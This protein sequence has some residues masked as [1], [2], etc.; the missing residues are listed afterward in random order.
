MTA[1]HVAEVQIRDVAEIDLRGQSGH[2]AHAQ[3]V[4]IQLIGLMTTDP[5]HVGRIFTPT[6][7]NHA[8]CLIPAFRV[9][10]QSGGTGH[11]QR[12]CINPRLK[13]LTQYFPLP[14]ACPQ[15]NQRFKLALGD[16]IQVRLHVMVGKFRVQIAHPAL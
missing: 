2:I 10:V 1:I 13:R 16:G 12:G 7:L 14:L 6:A 9:I 11:V 5:G 8:R 4:K 3:A 15:I